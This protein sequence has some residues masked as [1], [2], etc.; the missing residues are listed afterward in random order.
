MK[1][2]ILL[3]FFVMI[4]TGCAT[5]HMSKDLR[6]DFTNC[7]EGKSTNIRS[8]IDIDGYYIMYDLEGYY[9]GFKNEFKDTL[10]INMIFY[11][12]GTFLYNFSGVFDY[13]DDIPGYLAKVAQNGDKDPFYSGFDWGVYRID[14]DI[15]KAQYINH[16][17]GMAPWD[18]REE[19]FKIV[20]RKTIVSIYARRL[21]VTMT[22][23][24]RKNY[25]KAISRCTPARFVPLEVIPPPN[26]W[27]KNDEWFW[28]KNRK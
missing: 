26:C 17:S 20:D 25:K 11:E 1:A 3:V 22:E 14:G 23:V 27:L 24:A 4:M 12:D 6:K 16:A 8:L 13:R 21:G 7:F 10:D 28:C 2:I 18:A 15:I 19:W 9:Y 5:K